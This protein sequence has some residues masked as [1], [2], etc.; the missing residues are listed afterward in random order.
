M[1]RFVVAF[2]VA[3]LVGAGAAYWT[4]HTVNE[5]Q[6]MVCRVCNRP[7]HPNSRTVALVGGRRTWFCCPAC[8]LSEHEQS[9]QPVEVVELSNYRNGQTID[10]KHAWVVRDS[11]VNPCKQHQPAVNA[12]SQ[13]LQARYDRCSPS[14]LSFPDQSSAGAFAAEHGGQVM[15]FTTLAAGYEK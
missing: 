2:T 15:S 12:D 11:D 13:P 9:G 8:A 6:A 5:R 1:V 10:P 4:W 3:L 14:I 7:V